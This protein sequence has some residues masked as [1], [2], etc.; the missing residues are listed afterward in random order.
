MAANTA[1]PLN[2]DIDINVWGPFTAEDLVCDGTLTDEPLRSTWSGVQGVTGLID[3][4]PETGE[5]VDDICEG[6][7]GDKFV[8]TIPVTTG[9]WYV[10]LINDFGGDIMDGA[11]DMDFT[12]TSDGVLGP[13]GEVATISADTTLCA[14]EPVQLLATGGSLF[15]WEDN[16]ALSCTNCPNPIANVTETT[17]FE[18]GIFGACNSD[19]LSVQ[20]AVL[21]NSD[22][23][24]NVNVVECSDTTIVQVTEILTDSLFVITS[25]NW[26]L[27]VDGTT[28]TSTEENPDFEITEIGMATLTLTAINDSGCS[29]TA[30]QEFTVD[31]EV[32]VLD[33][34]PDQT[35]D[36]TTTSLVLDASMDFESYL[37]STTETTN[38]ITVTEGGTY[39]VTVTDVCGNTQTDEVIVTEDTTIP[40][41]DIPANVAICSG[42]SFMYD[43]PDDFDFYTWMPSEGLSCT[44]C[45]SPIASPTE[46]T[47]YTLMVGNNNGCIGMATSQITVNPTI[48]STVAL[49]ACEGETVTFNGMD[50]AI[51]STTDFNFMTVEGCDSIVTVT[52]TSLPNVVSTVELSACEGETVDFNGTALAIGSTTDFVFPAANG[53]DSTVTV[54]VS[55]LPVF[56]SNLSLSACEGQTVT[57]EGSELMPGTTTDFTFQAN[58]GCDSVVTV[59]VVAL[60]NVT[61]SEMISICGGE[62][63]DIFGTP[64]SAPG[65]YEMTFTASNGCDSTHTITLIIFDAFEVVLI[66]TNNDCAGDLAGTATATISDGGDAPFTFLWDTGATT[67]VI[68]GLAAATYSVTVTDAN[69]CTETGNVA[70]EEP[71]SIDLT[72][73]QVNVGCDDFGSATA[74]AIGG[75]GDI[76]YEWSTG[77]DEATIDSLL[78]GTFTV[79]ATDENGC[80]MSQDVVI[81]G[82]FGPEISIQ[83]DELPSMSSLMGG[84]LSVN[85]DGGTAPFTYLWNTGATTST[86]EDLGSGMYIV[87]VT[88]ANGCIDEAEVILFIPGCIRGRI[89][90]DCNR[91]GCQDTGENGISGIEL[92]L[93]GMDIFGNPVTLTTFTSGSGKYSFQPLPPGTFE[94]SYVD[95]DDDLYT[96]SPM[97][98]CNNDGQ[99]SDFNVNSESYTYELSEGD[100]PTNLDGGLFDPCLNVLDAG[101]ICCDQVLCGPGNVPNPITSLAPATGAGGAVE[102]MWMKNI[103][104]TNN[105]LGIMGTNSP[106]Y[107]PG[108]LYE[109]T[110]FARCSRAV[111]CSKWLETNIVQIFVDDETV[112]EINGP[113][114]MCEGDIVTYTAQDN[115][116]GATYEWSFGNLASPSTA[117]GQTVNVMWNFFT[118]TQITLTVTKGDCT[119]TNFMYVAVSNSDV[120]CGSSMSSVGTVGNFNNNF[121]QS[122]VKEDDVNLAQYSILTNPINDNLTVTWNQMVEGEISLKLFTI[123]GQ[124]VA[125]ATADGERLEH[126]M[127]TANLT[128]GLYLLHVQDEN[129]VRETMKVFKQ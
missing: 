95:L 102:Y 16:P 101:M 5:V 8:S 118:T 124:Q 57:Y 47:T 86:L 77:S 2:S 46:T 104:G 129:G 10:V 112:A 111:G 36:C 3:I 82:A 127:S 64:T 4:N 54:N 117:T 58:N 91:D 107:A 11:I 39:S 38:T 43:V 30:T 128:N 92:S 25:F 15:Q 74:S 119:S 85:I 81:T 125:T 93:N 108:A 110:N 12:F 126:K 32:L 53:C 17:T 80:T 109:T 98:A 76:T 65:D 45:P 115:G 84:E 42:G 63:I 9:E 59:M 26:E 83:I 62:S 56:T 48:T 50:L 106:N 27:V 68:T 19:T 97:D 88:D 69:G 24:F 14:G 105:W 96:I 72:T 89:F 75:T 18:V 29:S 123:G 61:S 60:P 34:G 71:T 90:D 99:D 51:G 35:L 41:P 20:I 73:T 70:V 121:A 37:W 33:L 31:P 66:S 6:A 87:T 100:C 94:I 21:D 22:I 55:A 52:V 13:I 7:G 40:A 116:A 120:Y 1:D 122:V 79:T 113:N 114:S 103:D 23:D 78:A 49:E 67:P 28:Y 44:D